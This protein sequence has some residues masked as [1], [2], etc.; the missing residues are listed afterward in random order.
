MIC[1]DHGGELCAPE[2]LRFVMICCL[3]THIQTHMHID[4]L[5]LTH[6]YAN[7]N[8]HYTHAHT[9]TYTHTLRTHAHTHTQGKSED[10][11]SMQCI[12]AC[13]INFHELVTLKEHTHTHSHAHTDAHT[14]THTRRERGHA[15]H[16]IHRSMCPR[17]PQTCDL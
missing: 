5:P 9:H 11:P 3:H 14:C 12:A 17:R 13:V 15:D 4:D 16:A 1:I 8:A 7:I 6:T 2:C 10:T